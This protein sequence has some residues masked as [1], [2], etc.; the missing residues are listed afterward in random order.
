MELGEGDGKGDES[1]CSLLVFHSGVNTDAEV[2]V[3]RQHKASQIPRAV[4]L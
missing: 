4:S 2:K 1:M 3:S